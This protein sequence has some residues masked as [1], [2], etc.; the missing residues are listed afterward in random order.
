MRSKD[1]G[2]EMK[3]H[4]HIERAD[5]LI[6]MVELE[7]PEQPDLLPDWGQNHT[8]AMAALELARAH[9]AIAEVKMIGRMRAT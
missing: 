5:F 2:E 4:E 9:I 8:R 3:P 1:V 6:Y 7:G